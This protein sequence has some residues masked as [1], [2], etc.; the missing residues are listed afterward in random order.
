M[1]TSDVPVF[2]R[3]YLAYASDE[4]VNHAGEVVQCEWWPPQ[5]NSN[6]KKAQ[7]VCQI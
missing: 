7:G 3:K 2:S 5:K 4:E 6:G 1:G